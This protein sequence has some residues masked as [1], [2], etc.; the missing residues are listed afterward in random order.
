MQEFIAGEGACATIIAA[1]IEGSKIIYSL[2]EASRIKDSSAPTN[3]GMSSRRMV[4]RISKSILS[5]RDI[6][7]SRL[8]EDFFPEKVAEASGSV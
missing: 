7:K 5:C 4:Q 1:S 2:I 3:D 6:K 8:L